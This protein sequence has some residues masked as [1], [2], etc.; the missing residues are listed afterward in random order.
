MKE[1]LGALRIF[2]HI[3]EVGC[4]FQAAM[5]PIK[6]YLIAFK[7][8][9]LLSQLICRTDKV[10]EVSVLQTESKWDDTNTLSV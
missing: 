5:V 1:A 9:V 8:S 3:L 7:A 4:K 10:R 2:A 6:I